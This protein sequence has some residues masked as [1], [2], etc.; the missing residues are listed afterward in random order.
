[1]SLGYDFMPLKQ[2]A[3]MSLNDSKRRVATHNKILVEP[4]KEAKYQQE[5]LTQVTRISFSSSEIMHILDSF[6]L[7]I[8]VHFVGFS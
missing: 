7:G 4:Q 3:N 2:I 6:F 8:L 5:I 1:M